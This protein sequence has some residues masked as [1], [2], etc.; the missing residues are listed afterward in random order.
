MELLFSGL[1]RGNVSTLKVLM[2]SPLSWTSAGTRLEFW[3]GSEQLADAAYVWASV[4][5][6]LWSWAFP[7]F[8][9]S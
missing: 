9:L 5:P 1:D 6:C 7:L 8:W 3:P 4:L 2:R